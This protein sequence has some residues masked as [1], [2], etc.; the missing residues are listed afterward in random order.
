RTARCATA[1]RAT[2]RAATAAAYRP[3]RRQAATRRCAR[4]TSAAMPATDS[5]LRPPRCGFRQALAHALEVARRDFRFVDEVSDQRA[6]IG[7]E[8][9]AD[10]VGHHRT[11]HV[12]FA[13]LRAIDQLA[14]FAALRDDV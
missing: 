5:C 8:Q 2:R 1:T 9:A 10:Q 6:R 11:A 7:A 14:A 3:P 13:D 4:T 12:R